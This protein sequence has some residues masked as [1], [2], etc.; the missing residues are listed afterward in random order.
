MMI[1]PKPLVRA[2]RCSPPRW[3]LFIFPNISGLSAITYGSVIWH[4][5]TGIKEGKKDVIGKLAVIQNGC[6]RAIAGAYKTT[7]I[8]ALHAETMMMPM[9]EQ[10]DMLQTKARLSQ[11]WRAGSVYRETKQTS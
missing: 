7:P 8:E 11:D 6:L 5:P 9:Q 3:P 4:A 2:Y 1:V 10:P